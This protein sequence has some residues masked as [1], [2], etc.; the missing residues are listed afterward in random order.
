MSTATYRASFF[1]AE[2]GTHETYK[3]E[4]E[5]D[6]FRRPA[7]DV[8]DR[9][10]GYMNVENS[11]GHPLSYELNSAVKKNDMRIVMASGSLL[12]ERGEIPFMVMISPELREI[13][14]QVP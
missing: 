11:Y 12:L 13:T 5:N 14:V 7:D 2:T 1:D 3:F 4:A 9:F 8:V 6:L 10:I